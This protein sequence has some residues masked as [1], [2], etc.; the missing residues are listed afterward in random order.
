MPGFTAQDLIDRA[1]AIADMH[2]NFV[3]PATWL[4]W[5]NTERQAL[6]VL[7]LR[8]GWNLNRLTSVDFAAANAHPY[9]YIT[10]FLAVV[11][12]WE[13]MSSGTLRQLIHTNFIDFNRQSDSTGPTLGHPT[14]WAMDFNTDTAE[15]DFH[16]YPR[17]TS[18]TFRLVVA[19][20]SPTATATTDAMAFPV[21]IEEWIVLRMA[22]RALVKEESDTS[23]IDRL[24]SS[25]EQ[26]IEE[27][28]W[29]RVLGEVPA[30]RNTD[31]VNRAWT[32]QMIYP[33]P[34]TWVFA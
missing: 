1:A 12:V 33:P 32:G 30:A 26:R 28:C 29:A 25:E 17:P 14:H 20:I 21:G 23:A 4:S 7:M 34:A 27:L 2:D 8:S 6:D 22:R 10:D 18:G 19:G 9:A 15:Y 3:S 16:F 5:L 11:G 31:L 13:V 24:I